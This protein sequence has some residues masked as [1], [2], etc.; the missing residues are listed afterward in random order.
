[1]K[2]LLTMVLVLN[3]TCAV[4]GCGGGDTAP[5]EPPPGSG[6]DAVDDVPA[7]NDG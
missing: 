7:T 1:M 3:L 6:E 5:A 2:K 4:I